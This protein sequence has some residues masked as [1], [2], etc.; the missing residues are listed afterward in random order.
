M[1]LWPVNISYARP[2]RWTAEISQVKNRA[3][4]QIDVVV[5]YFVLFEYVG[6]KFVFVPTS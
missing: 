6:S 4:T 1:G 3:Y 5:T 2:L